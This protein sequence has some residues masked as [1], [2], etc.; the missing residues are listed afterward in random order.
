MSGRRPD[1]WEYNSGHALGLENHPRSSGSRSNYEQADFG[2]EPEH[3]NSAPVL[4][5]LLRVHTD[6]QSTDVIRDLSIQL[7]GFESFSI[8]V[9]DSLAAQHCE[10]M[11]DFSRLAKE[12]VLADIFDRRSG[13]LPTKS[14]SL[15]DY[16][17]FDAWESSLIEDQLRHACQFRDALVHAVS[18]TIQYPID[19][20]V[21]LR[22]KCRDQWLEFHRLSNAITS[23]DRSRAGLQFGHLLAA[24]FDSIDSHQ[25][26]T[27]KLHRLAIRW[28]QL[29][30]ALAMLQWGTGSA[31]SI[32]EPDAP[33]RPVP[34]YKA[35]DTVDKP[36]VR[37]AT[38]SPAPP[39]TKSLSTCAEKWDKATEESDTIAAM[40]DP[41]KRNKVISA[42]YAEVYKKDS[43]MLWSGT[44]AFASKQVGC[45]LEKAKR[46]KSWPFAIG[47]HAT[48]MYTGL[49]IGNKA[50]F[51]EIYPV[52]DFYQEHGFESISECASS[53]MPPVAP[54][55]IDAIK[56]IDA[57]DLEAGAKKML[58]HEQSVTLQNE[59]YEREEFVAA[60]DSNKLWHGLY[61]GRPF[62]AEELKL[63]FTSECSGGKEVVFEGEALQEFDQRWEYA[64]T[65]ADTFS[66]LATNDPAFIKSELDKILSAGGG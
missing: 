39:V 61:V 3:C 23:V 6:S 54:A 65:V 50:V 31:V 48:A 44:A 49:G 63:S 9:I 10:S 45:G 8:G 62:G 19:R 26:V 64:Q 59:V 2:H 32:R 25:G 58:R 41:V 29:Q 57:N 5:E 36:V 47:K 13:V 51:E 20:T 28:P 16:P 66:E 34:L 38:H 17:G 15:E 4:H 43:R 21:T 35:L 46:K 40:T 37:P 52:M 7:L 42:K 18:E 14:R 55:L 11:A 22:A 60:L 30:R 27:L 53:R 12:L 33:S 1:S 24:T 56:K